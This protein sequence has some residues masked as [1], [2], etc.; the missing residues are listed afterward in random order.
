M[1]IVYAK[2]DPEAYQ[3]GI[4]AFIVEKVNSVKE[5]VL[6]INKCLYLCI[7]IY[8][9]CVGNTGILDRTEARQTRHERL[10]HL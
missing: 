1:L 6:I 7:Y 8:T 5:G 9:L 10:K 4:T 2:T 3:K